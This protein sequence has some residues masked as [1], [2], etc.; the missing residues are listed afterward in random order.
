M[1]FAFA[2]IILSETAVNP[3]CLLSGRFGLGV[4]LLHP[5]C[6]DLCALGVPK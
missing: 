2:Q 5:Q 1:D 3:H 6:P 4:S